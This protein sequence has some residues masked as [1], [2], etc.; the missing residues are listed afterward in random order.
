MISA[1]CVICSV[2]P[3]SHGLRKRTTAKDGDDL[4]RC[5]Q[6][7]CDCDV[8]DGPHNPQC[9]ILTNGYDGSVLLEEDIKWLDDVRMLHSTSGNNLGGQEEFH[10]TDIGVFDP[11]VGF[12]VSGKEDALRPHEDGFLMH[13]ACFRMLQLAYGQR[14]LDI[15]GIYFLIQAYLENEASLPGSDEARL[16]FPTWYDKRLYY[17]AARFHKETGWFPE[18]GQEWYVVNPNK[19][20]DYS[21]VVN[22]AACPQPHNQSHPIKKLPP[23]VDLEALCGDVKD[24]TSQNKDQSVDIETLCELIRDAS[25]MPGF[26]NME[27]L[28]RQTDYLELKNRRRIWEGCEAIL[29]KLSP[30]L[31][32]TAS[33]AILSHPRMRFASIRDRPRVSDGHG[34]IISSWIY[35]PTDTGGAPGKSNSR[36]VTVYFDPSGSIIGIKW[37]R[38]AHETADQGEKSEGILFGLKTGSKESNNIPDGCTII[39]IFLSLGTPSVF[40]EQTIRGFIIEHT[41]GIIVL[42]SWVP[43]ADIV[44]VFRPTRAQPGIIVG[45]AGQFNQRHIL[46]FGII[47]MTPRS[48]HTAD[49][50]TA[51]QVRRKTSNLDIYTR[52]YPGY[53]PIDAPFHVKMNANFSLGTCLRMTDYTLNDPALRPP[54]MEN[55]TAY[56]DLTRQLVSVTASFLREGGIVGLSFAFQDGV[57]LRVPPLLSLPMNPKRAYTQTVRFDAAAEEKI[58]GIICSLNNNIERT[59]PTLLI[60]LRLFTN[61]DRL[62]MKSMGNDLSE[63]TEQRGRPDETVVGLHIGMGFAGLESVGLVT[64]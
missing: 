40:T 11:K 29:E 56:I 1:Y 51:P 33:P 22:A 21:L 15:K 32:R 61:K 9:G 35:F 14:P 16:A 18:A 24:F 62:N 57:G 46:T 41:Q 10:V 3:F 27:T 17:G 13:D 25:Y 50:V 53:S 28:S 7:V 38:Q 20:T 44:Q 4:Q 37:S 52:W 39:G 30:G 43:L 63:P 60:G 19:P 54:I 12:I 31:V 48:R 42:G 36:R 2:Q 58:V 47:T 45:I 5:Y 49:H 64:I 59:T 6:D 23:W 55:L 8:V 34:E 26:D